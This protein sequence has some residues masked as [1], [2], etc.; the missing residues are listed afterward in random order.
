MAK[1]R[2]TGGAVQQRDVHI[3]SRSREGS[4]LLRLPPELRNEIYSRLFFSTRFS[5]G[6]RNVSRVNHVRIIPASNGLALLQTCRQARGEVGDTWLGQ[7]LFSFEDIETMLDKLTTLPI[8]VLSKIRHL[9]IRDDAI[10]LSEPLGEGE[11]TVYRLDLALKLLPGLYLDRL[12]VLG[13]PNKYERYDSLSRLIMHGNGWAEL[14]YISHDSR[15]LSYAIDSRPFSNDHYLRKP[16][17][18][19]WESLL[20]N[21]DDASSIPSVAIYRSILERCGSVINPGTREQYEQKISDRENAGE[22]FGREEDVLL[23]AHGER[24]KELLVVAKRGI[25]VDY[26]EKLGS[27]FLEDDIP[28]EMPGKAWKEIRAVCVDRALFGDE[29]LAWEFED[30][31]EELEEVDSYEHVDD[32]EWTPL[33]LNDETL[34]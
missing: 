18:A 4:L 25:G 22:T 34:I 26:E 32:Y 20:V 17:P 3:E 24:D 6:K 9:R 23:K 14:H 11:V 19:Y 33:H 1:N 13:C 5:Y 10:F 27:P 15:M 12:T 21:R 7:A 30:E 31:E 8:R 29:D 2:K 28:R 16:Q